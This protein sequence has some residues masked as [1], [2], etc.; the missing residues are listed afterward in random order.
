MVLAA[1]QVDGFFAE[2][3]Q[4]PVATGVG[5]P[6]TASDH[7]LLL[8]TTAEHMFPGKAFSLEPSGKLK[9]TPY[10]DAVW[11]RPILLPVDGI[12]SLHAAFCR[13]AEGADGA[14]FVVRGRVWEGAD[15]RSI[16]RRKNGRKT[17]RR[18]NVVLK[19]RPRGLDNAARHWGVLDMDKIPNLLGLD[20]RREPEQAIEFLR[21]LLPV[22]LQAVRLSWQWSSST[23]VLGADGRQLPEGIA[24][25]T[26]GAH[27]RFWADQPM[28]E[29]E[30]RA[31]LKR[32]NAYVTERLTGMG[33]Q[34]IH[35]ARYVD[36]A[37]ATYTQPI[38]T[39]RPRFLDGAFDPLPGSLRYGLTA[40]GAPEVDIGLL[41]AE[42]P[43]VGSKTSKTAEQLAEGKRIRAAAVAAKGR[44]NNVME[45]TPGLRR[46]NERL[47]GSSR[48]AAHKAS[49]D[50]QR[51]DHAWDTE[52]R[53]LRERFVATAVED[54]K[55]IYRVR[56][57]SDMRK[58][59]VDLVE[60]DPDWMEAQ[61]IPAGMRDHL[62]F[63][64][65]CMLARVISHPGHL[66]G[67]IRAW[68]HGLVSEHW[69]E[70]EWSHKG[71]RAVIDRAV[72]AHAGYGNIWKGEVVDP[73]Y[74]D[75]RKDDLIQLLG[76]TEEQMIRLDLEALITEAVRSHNRRRAKG[77]PTA[78]EFRARQRVTS[79]KHQQPWAEVGVSETTWRRLK[80]DAR[81]MKLDEVTGYTRP[82]T[83]RKRQGWTT[84]RWVTVVATV[85]SI[86]ETEKSKRT[87]EGV[88]RAHSNRI[89]RL[90]RAAGWVWNEDAVPWDPPEACWLPPPGAPSTPPWKV[91]QPRR[92]PRMPAVDRAMVEDAD[93]IEFPMGRRRAQGPA[94]TSA[95][96]G[97]VDV[98]ILVP[99]GW[100]S[101][102]KR[103]AA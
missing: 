24:P 32:I 93:I 99:R 34:V 26:L 18:G 7:V 15:P 72:Q 3:P 23:C 20:P 43:Q 57:L 29:L 94:T 95:S 21:S 80:R 66:R 45:F 36:S 14:G 1:K 38:Y 97:V 35:G 58:V 102:H 76:I 2:R 68:A 64:A 90:A 84:D 69:Y 86:R 13:T 51:A 87:A 71:D 46:Q 48:P 89:A 16:T 67:A 33:V 73:R 61:G 100:R 55:A 9:L 28:A 31:T 22:T 19:G 6:A 78:A 11:F 4:V 83:R 12:D 75:P 10:G 52:N 30:M 44:A 56:A 79:E 27:L 101:E 60:N 91:Q 103:R 17:Q 96:A 59:I 53:R 98:A 40:N 65:A 92:R 42:L 37:T 70:T 77:I 47:A 39:L 82:G 88:A 49:A 8:R 50:K 62:M 63:K 81:A 41:L 74:A 25:S 54:R 85:R 5:L